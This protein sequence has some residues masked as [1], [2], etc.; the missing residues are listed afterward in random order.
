[1][2]MPLVQVETG[3]YRL[4]LDAFAVHEIL[5]PEPSDFSS[6]AS[7][8]AWRNEVLPV[9]DTRLLLG[10]QEKS[11]CWSSTVLVYSA[12]PEQTLALIFDGVIGIRS[13][14]EAGAGLSPLPQ[15]LLLPKE[16]YQLFDGVIT[17][18]TGPVRQ[19]YHIRRPFDLIKFYQN[20]TARP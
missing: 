15:S 9:M 19:I 12:M 6:D 1:M 5:Q 7:Q 20:M 4:L 17:D 18:T 13:P 2:N 14:G 10:G 8:M 16:V 11:D 3:G